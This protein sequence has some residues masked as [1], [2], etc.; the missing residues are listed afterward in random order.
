ML[1]TKRFL[2]VTATALA[3][4][5]G[6]AQAAPWQGGPHHGGGGGF[7]HQ[8]Q[9][10]HDELKLTPSQD[11]LW[12]NA[13][14]VSKANRETERSNRKQEMAQMKNL[15]SQQIL[16]LNA[17]NAMHEKSADQSRQLHEQSTA[18]WLNVYNALT[19]IQKAIVS[20]TLKDHFGH[21]HWGH[22]MHHHFEHGDGQG[23]AGGHWAHGGPEGHDGHG[24]HGAR[25]GMPASAPGSAPGSAPAQ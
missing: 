16:D 4:S 17:L 20:T 21:H 10:L 2:A 1:N 23:P 9:R 15:D 6:V 13:V 18:A 19:D 11:K 12:Q 7:E 8:V 3:V 24:M 22:R 5:F 14:S 25:P